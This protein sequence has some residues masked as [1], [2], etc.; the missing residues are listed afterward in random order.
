MLLS[1]IA[2]ARKLKKQKIMLICKSNLISYYQNSGFN[3]AG[4]SASSHG[5]FQWHEMYLPLGDTP[6]NL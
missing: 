5:G 1:F 2:E 3:Y 6:R 4:E